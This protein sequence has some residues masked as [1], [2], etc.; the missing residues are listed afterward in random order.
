MTAADRLRA[1]GGVI[2]RLRGTPGIEDLDGIL[3]VRWSEG[4]QEGWWWGLDSWLGGVDASTALAADPRLREP[5]LRSGA[6]IAQALHRATALPIRVG[7]AEM[8]DWVDRHVDVL[9]TLRVPVPR[10]AERLGLLQTRLRRGLEGRDVRVGWVHGDLWRGNLRVDPVTGDITGLIDWDCA[11]PGQL[12][13]HDLLHLSLYGLAADRGVD[14]GTVLV[15][16]LR[17]GRWP[18]EVESVVAPVRE[19]WGD[20]RDEDLLLLYWLRHVALIAL[21]QREYLEHSRLVWLWRNV[22]KVLFAL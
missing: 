12:P 15:E 21:Q 2:A 22:A 4:R 17:A 8:R 7:E 6:A 14:L 13:I 18:S 16:V 20:V 3:P 10:A 11:A 9:R 19:A 5:V 1:E